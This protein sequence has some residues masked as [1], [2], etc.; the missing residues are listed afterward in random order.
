VFKDQLDQLAKADTV[1]FGGVGIAGTML[2]ATQAYFAL[3]EAIHQ[4]HVELR[5]RLDELLD[6]ATPAGRIY[7]GELLAHIAADAGQAAWGRL[8]GQHHDVTT[9]N[10]CVMVRTTLAR[11]ASQRLRGA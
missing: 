4:H 3:E 5:A 8:A 7:A 6:T 9:M 2:P 1:A 10:G 11:Y